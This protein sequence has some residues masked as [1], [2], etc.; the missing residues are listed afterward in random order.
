[1]KTVKGARVSSRLSKR[2]ELLLKA[3]EDGGHK[4]GCIHLKPQY[5]RTA[6]VPDG[7]ERPITCQCIPQ[8]VVCCNCKEKVA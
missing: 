7:V 6:D 3:G 8:R 1:M 4:Y 2:K 5:D